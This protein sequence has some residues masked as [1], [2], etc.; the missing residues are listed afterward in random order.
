MSAGAEAP[1]SR[2][3]AVWGLVAALF[4]AVVSLGH[5]QF[6]LWLVKERAPLFGISSFNQLVPFLAIAGALSLAAWLA[7]AVHR[8][9]RPLTWLAYWA[10]WAAC[11]VAA[12]R[13]LTYSV[14]EYAHY[15]QYALLAWLIARAL[16]PDRRRLVLGRVMLWTALLGIVDELQQYLWITSSYSEYLDFNDFLVN[17]LASA[18]GAMLYY[19]SRPV[20]PAAHM[21]RFPS[22]ETWAALLIAGAVAGALHTGLVVVTPAGDIPPGGLSRSPDG[23]LRLYLQRRP[24]LYGSDNAGPYRGTYRILDPATGLA[25]MLGA[26]ALFATSPMVLRRQ[27]SRAAAWS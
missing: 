7:L 9:H 2:S 16:D 21:P 22:L 18:A 25:L 3:G 12:D 15:P 19:C 11:V 24:G 5:L 13:F 1:S 27:P 17:L 10:L 20:A 23:V 8:S 6:S 4:F 14:A 26:G